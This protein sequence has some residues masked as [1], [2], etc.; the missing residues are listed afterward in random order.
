MKYLSNLCRYFSKLFMKKEETL[1][2]RMLKFHIANT[3]RIYR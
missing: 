1:Y 3:T 2:V